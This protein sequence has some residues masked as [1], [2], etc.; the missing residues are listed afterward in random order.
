MFIAIC[1]FSYG[2]RVINVDQAPACVYILL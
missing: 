2:P 1:F